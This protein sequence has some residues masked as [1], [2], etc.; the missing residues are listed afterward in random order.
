MD[1]PALGPEL[2]RFLL[3][4][5]PDQVYFKD[6]KG[7]FFCASRAVAEYMGVADPADLT[8]KTDFDFWSEET[9]RNTAADERRILETGQPLLGKV[10]KLTHP[11][12]RVTW[13]YTS[14]LPL[15]NSRGD[16]IGIFGINKDFTALKVLQDALEAERNQLRLTMAELAARN[17]QLE[18][19]LRMAREIQLALL[20]REYPTVGGY[21][22]S[23]HPPFHFAHYYRPAAAVGGDF[24]DIFPLSDTRAGVFICDVM[25]HGLRAALVT[26]II[27][28]LLEELRPIMFNASRFLTALNLRLRAI[29]ERVDEPF[30]ATGFYMIVDAAMTEVQ[31]AN[32]A[33][34][35]PIRIR[36]SANA[37][38]PLTDDKA[39]IGP[40]LGLFDDITYTAFTCPL[41]PSDRLL[42]FTD[43]LY[44]MD[45]PEG[46]EF[47]Q[48][49]L[50]SS[51][52]RFG[53]LPAEQ[54]FSA[55]MDDV[56]RF[57]SRQDFEDDVCM[58]VVERAR[59]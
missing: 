6:T 59:D 58:V 1:D 44:E 16:V 40:G 53:T 45:S 49:A 48:N 28:T 2:F 31:F 50:L 36:R 24:F 13:D 26:A 8:G 3:A 33:H 15:R 25:G 11:D 41:D 29:L 23:G 47:G 51:L 12:G 9:A 43:G 14:K 52:Q 39:K 10:E 35:L 21:G 37:V 34:P 55:V 30:V 42:L 17:A 20:P 7:R 19:D 46:K 57:S 27:R 32:A 56:R 54:L 4:N 38:E 22:I 18:A 5:T